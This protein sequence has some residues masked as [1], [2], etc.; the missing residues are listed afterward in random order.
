MGEVDVL[1]L[2]ERTFYAL[3][4]RN[5]SQV[6]D[7]FGYIQIIVEEAAILIATDIDTQIGKGLHFH[8]SQFMLMPDQLVPSQVK[9][10]PRNN[11]IE[12]VV[13]ISPL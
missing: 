6:V 13:L 12:L 9:E 10:D 2:G 11:L 8:Q 1:A 3:M 7:D 5:K 4:L